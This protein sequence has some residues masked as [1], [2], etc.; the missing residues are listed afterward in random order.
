MRGKVKQ[1]TGRSLTGVCARASDLRQMLYSLTR[2][3]HFNPK[4]P[5]QLGGELVILS[6]QFFVRDATSAVRLQGLAADAIAPCKSGDLVVV[7]VCGATV[8][9]LQIQSIKQLHASQRERPQANP[10]ALAFTG[11]LQRVRQFFLDSGLS[12]ISTPSLVLC[13]GTE[14][15]LEP[16]KTE[17]IYGS[18]RRDV[19]LPTSP[20]IHLKK[21]LAL[22]GQDLFEIKSCYRQGEL[23]E[24]HEIEFSMLE[25]YRPFSDLELLI[26]D[27]QG[28]L[29]SLQLSGWLAQPVQLA[30]TDFATLFKEL[31]AFDLRPETTRAELLLLLQ[32]QSID[33]A[34]TDT[35][36][37]L[38]HRLMIEI[39]ESHLQTKGPIIVRNFPPSQAALA[40]I[41]S[42]G[43]ADRFEFYWNGMEIANAFNEVTDAQEQSQRWQ[44][45]LT[46]RARLGTSAIPID[47][48][49]LEA[50]QM[51]IPPTAG[52]ALGVERLYM[53]AQGVK[54]I[55][56]LRLFS[57]KDLLIV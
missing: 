44:R 25:W 52:I 2:W 56:Q 1:R 43:W 13:P 40:K 26:Q 29:R 20:E 39:V 48:G 18:Q 31:F 24:H 12:E 55:R 45:D 53:A 17:I 34:A 49:L 32:R 22:T 3:R 27:I 28:L 8:D 35:F 50:L 37:D 47:Q 42:E 9:Q 16:L 54:K 15:V 5:F 7:E 36:D 11:F 4:P 19:Y 23:T 38:F 21:A 10:H 6:G 41:N 51:G 57:A 33:H 46:E 14:P 30:V